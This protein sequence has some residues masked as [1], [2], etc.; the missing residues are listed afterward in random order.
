MKSCNDCKYAQWQK[1]RTGKL[2]PSGGGQCGYDYKIPP[3][4]GAFFFIGSPLK[5][6]GIINRRKE[7]KEHCAYFVRI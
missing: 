3:L 1:T 2:H 5:C 7:L 4:P 6:G